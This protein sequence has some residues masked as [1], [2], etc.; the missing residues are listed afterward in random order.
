MKIGIVGCGALGCF[1]GA[2][3][4]RIGQ[5]VHLLLRSDYEVVRDRGLRIRSVDGEQLMHPHAYDDPAD[6]GECDLVIVSLKTTANDRFS[7]LISPL[8]DND[9]AILCLQ[10]G[11]GNCE[12]LGELF[13]PKRVMGGQCFVCLNRTEPGV[14]QHIAFGKIVMGNLG[15]PP[16]E[17]LREIVEMF[18]STRI[19]CE[20]AESLEQGQ[21]EK[22]VW[23]IPFNGLGVAAT[24]GLE[25]LD[26]AGEKMPDKPG[27]VLTTEQLLGNS[28]W[29]TWVR[30]L[31]AEIINAANAKGLDIDSGLSERMLE[32]TRNMGE[33]R[34]SALIDF[35]RGQPLELESI[36]L[37]PLR[38]ASI[39]GIDAPRLEAL[40]AVLSK[41]DRRS[42]LSPGR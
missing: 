31:M 3:L 39:A 15:R 19:P 7:E 4:C 13:G 17:R 12:Q 20:V 23:N 6:I 38:Q 36:F 1:Y 42:S 32:Y 34:A 10:N 5:D 14:V 2:R 9:T 27:P 26:S 16:T 41:L 22:L 25:A 8:L 33:Y 18:K 21:W 11:L 28:Q 40:C 29:E 30:G 35:E 24:A 37:E